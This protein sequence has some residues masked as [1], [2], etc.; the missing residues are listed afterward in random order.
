M[1]LV[2]A[3]QVSQAGR[4]LCLSLFPELVSA[5]W[6]EVK[7]SP[8][9]NLAAIALNQ[10]SKGLTLSSS[11]QE[12]GNCIAGWWREPAYVGPTLLSIMN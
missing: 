2:G 5:P 9:F 1:E 6:F 12:Q 8:N 3:C 4:C 10:M 11:L 7:K